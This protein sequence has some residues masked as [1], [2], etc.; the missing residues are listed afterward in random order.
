MKALFAAALVA[1]SLSAGSVIF[2]CGGMATVDPP[3]LQI[4]DGPPTPPVHSV[5]GDLTSCLVIC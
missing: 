4:D 5:V 2:A 1:V 3:T